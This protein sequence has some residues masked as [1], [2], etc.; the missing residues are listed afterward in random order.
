MPLTKKTMVLFDEE[1]YA[2]LEAFAKEHHMSVGRAI[3]ESVEAMVLKKG[4]VEERVKA[5]TRLT[6]AEEEPVDWDKFEKAL[7]RGHAG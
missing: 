7:S 1:R 5:A 3:R 2:K 6:S 4:D